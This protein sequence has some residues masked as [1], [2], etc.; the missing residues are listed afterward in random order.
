VCSSDL[1]TVREETRSAMAGLA[2]VGL[3]AACYRI[4]GS[5]L[6]I[7]RVDSLFLFLVMWFIYLA[8]QL[9]SIP[10]AILAGMAAALA[11]LTKQTAAFILLPVLAALFL[12]QGRRAWIPAATCAI[13]LGAVTLVMQYGSG[14]WYAYYTFDIL[15]QQAA[16]GAVSIQDFFLFDLLNRLPI[17]IFACAFFLVELLLFDRKR[18]LFWFA[19]FAGAIAAALLSR[20]KAGGFDNVLLPAYLGI[21]MLAGL[22]WGSISGR[23]KHF[24]V[25]IPAGQIAGCLLL[26]TQF[27]SLFYNPLH[28]IPS[29]TGEERQR[30]F[31]QFIAK[32]PGDVYVPYHGY[33]TALAGKPAFA[34]QAAI[35]DVLRGD[36]NNQGAQ[37]LKNSLAG[38]IALRRFGAIVMDGEWSFL[39]TMEQYYAQ[40][41]EGLPDDATF[42]ELVGWPVVP[43]MLWMPNRQP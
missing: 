20:M 16:W 38:A 1:A 15:R 2:A 24:P 13:L 40:V 34:H 42:Q 22:A 36:P 5:W 17:G 25:L 4:A 28:Q 37:S 33:V 8:R 27:V 35:W 14:G 26:C 6:D 11:Y 30:A 32:L 7:G 18:F 31:V 12:I 43:T 29:A 41:P 3:F 21:A 39:S 9:D 23:L 19:V 10:R